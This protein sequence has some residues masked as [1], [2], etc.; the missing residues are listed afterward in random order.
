MFHVQTG[1][2]PPRPVKRLE[3]QNT[4]AISSQVAM[5]ALALLALIYTLDYAQIIAAPIFL[6]VVIGL[7]LTPVADRLERLGLP[8]WLSSILI[9][10]LFL[11]L[12]VAAVVAFAVPL[13]AWAA[14]APQIWKSLQL[15]IASWKDLLSSVAAVQRQFTDVVGQTGAMTVKVANGDAVENMVTLAPAIVAE[16][17]LFF[18]SLYFFVATRDQFRLGVLKLCMT[19]RLRLRTARFFRDVEF[20]IARYLLTIS[21]INLGLGLSVSLGL[22]LVGVPSPLLWG[23][24]AAVLNYVV[25]V[26]PAVMVLLLFGVGLA[27]SHGGDILLAP[28]VYLFFNLIESQFVTNQVLG[29]S[30]TINPFAVFLALTFWLWLWGPIGGFIAVPSLL[31]L[32]ALVRTLLPF[33]PL[34][35]KVRKAR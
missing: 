11:F 4:I 2:K 12:V 1:S 30:M 8:S 20:L 13:S 7:M 34:P 22:W 35:R 23:G 10:L 28:G 27:T 33:P 25:Y 24:L 16:M 9:V 5:V 26:G 31:I 29:V 32:Q 17:L 3:L 14:Q 18:V 19:R 6:G 21:V 15:Q